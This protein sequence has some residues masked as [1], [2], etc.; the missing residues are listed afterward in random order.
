MRKT[1]LTIILGGLLFSTAQAQDTMKAGVNEVPLSEINPMAVN[2]E[3]SVIDLVVFYQPIYLRRM[4]GY[5][6]MVERINYQVELANESMM[7]NE[8]STRFVIRDI[9][10]MTG[11]PDELPFLNVLNEDGEVIED[12]AQGE[13]YSRVFSSEG[14]YDDEGNY[15][16]NYPEHLVFNQYRGDIAV[17]MTDYRPEND[18]PLGVASQAGEWSAVA[19]FASYLP[20]SSSGDLTLIHELGHN[21]DAGHSLEGEDP[22]ASAYDVGHAYKCDG[23]YTIMGGATT[24]GNE[25]N[26]F[27]DP[28]KSVNGDFCGAAGE[29][30]NRYV[31][32]QTSPSAAARKERKAI[33]G[34]VSFAESEFSGSE[35]SGELTVSLVR[36]GNFDQQSTVK[37]VLYSD[38]ASSVADVK[39]PYQY[40]TFD[41]GSDT[42]NAVF[43]LVDDAL[44]EGQEAFTARIQYP[45][46]L[47]IADGEAV[48]IVDEQT[49]SSPGMFSVSAE[50]STVTEGEPVTINVTRSNEGEGEVVLTL[51]TVS[52]TAG[53]VD[54]DAL[55]ETVVFNAD[56]FEKSY[57]INT[58][59]NDSADG[60]AEFSVRLSAEDDSIIETGE[61]AITL[62][63][64]EASEISYSVTI[65]QNIE[66]N[67]SQVTV[68]VVKENRND[69]ESS[70][71]VFTEDGSKVAGEDYKAIDTRLTFAAGESEQTVTIEL[72][73]NDNSSG[74]FYLN[75][76]GEQFAINLVAITEPTNPGGGDTDTETSGAAAGLFEVIGLLLMT[77]VA[78]VRRR[79]VGRE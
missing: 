52:G 22:E 47:T 9:R 29:A 55:Y 44:D 51:E 23:E 37:V 72:L 76:D 35:E 21:L 59:D 67:E 48:A 30:N 25:H 16:E 53:R 56:E 26:F 2:S 3:K 33:V 31:I 65:P 68:T 69:I 43:S 57:T 75:I 7:N 74:D 4:G 42:A 60:D 46:N 1:T 5:E 66:A 50:Q 34:S 28:N 19:D 62:A 32:E 73:G 61:V 49:S 58:V 64:D 8:Q 11:V 77:L 36:D 12:G 79:V 41:A 38:T 17:Y 27:S 24:T 6:N 10:Q 40:V 13:A 63:D 18:Q 14:Y 78:G 20:D 54:F 71:D 45:D 39:T 15:Q 70:V